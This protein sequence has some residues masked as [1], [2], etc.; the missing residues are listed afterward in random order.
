MLFFFLHAVKK[1]ENETVAQM[2]DH[3]DDVSIPDSWR[4]PEEKQI[5]ADVTKENRFRLHNSSL[6]LKR[7]SDILLA[8]FQLHLF[9]FL[10]ARVL[11]HTDWKSDNPNSWMGLLQSPHTYNPAWHLSTYIQLHLLKLLVVCLFC[12]DHLWLHCASFTLFAISL[13]LRLDP[14]CSC[15]D[16]HIIFLPLQQI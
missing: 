15:T 2:V 1:S 11:R 13:H 10:W 9:C 14:L 12:L 7:I 3:S 6:L 16:I 8:P 4:P 5:F